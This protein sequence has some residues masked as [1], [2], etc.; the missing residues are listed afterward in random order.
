[1]ALTDVQTNTHQASGDSCAVDFKFNSFPPVV[2]Y[3][4]NSLCTCVHRSF[5]V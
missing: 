1:M 2:R 5:L 3:V 4:I